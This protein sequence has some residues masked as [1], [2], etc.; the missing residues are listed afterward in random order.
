MKVVSS[1]YSSD[2]ESLKN[3]LKS[4]R[5]VGFT[6]DDTISM[7]NALNR[8]LANYHVHYQKLRNYHWNVKGDGFF[9][10][11][12][13]FGEQY[14]EVIVNIDQIVERIRVFGSIPMSTLR[15]YL[16]YAEIKETGT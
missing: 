7:V 4:F 6:R 13:E 8:L 1:T 14:Q 5:R 3:K 2:Y 11:H 9:D 16:D 12:K 10:L 15:E